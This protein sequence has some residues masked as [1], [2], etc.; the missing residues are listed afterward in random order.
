MLDPLWSF[1]TF[2]IGMDLGTANTLVYVKGLGIL[3]REPTVVAQHKKSK[4]TVAVGKSAKDMIGKTPENIRTIRPIANGVIADFEA[5]QALVQQ[6]LSQMHH[7]NGRWNKLPKPKVV[8]G[9]PSLVTEVERR[10]VVDAAKSA[11]ARSVYLVDESMASALGSGLLTGEAQG[12]LLIDIGGGTTEIAVVSLDGLVVSRSVPVAGWEMDEAIINYARETYQL[13]V[14]DQTAEAIKI[15]LGQAWEQSEERSALM[16][17]R[18]LITGLPR[19]VRVT[20]TEI[21]QAL[22]PILE[23]MKLLVQE[24]LEDTPPELAAD[25]TRSGI[26]LAGGGALIRGLDTYFANSLGMPAKVADEPLTAV[27]QGTAQLLD[28]P[29]LLKKLALPLRKANK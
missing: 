22:M 17:G 7:Q 12:R 4:A 13:L 15:E 18:D 2:D 21:Q 19:A 29:A 25:I 6:L 11:G 24:V 10:A 9:V 3:M 1:V 8:I 14:G 23:Q 27:V 26:T 28:D 16:G 5:T 20:S